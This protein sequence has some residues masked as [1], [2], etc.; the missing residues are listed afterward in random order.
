MPPGARR[1]FGQ[2][3]EAVREEAV[4]LK[5]LRLL[6]VDDDRVV[7]PLGAA[8][9]PAAVLVDDLEARD[10][11]QQA[12]RKLDGAHL[13]VQLH[14]IDA[15][16]PVFFDLGE[17]A[18]NGRDEQDVLD[19]VQLREGE[20]DGLLGR[21]LVLGAQHRSAV[22]EQGVLL[23]TFENRDAAVP[24]FLVVDQLRLAR[25]SVRSPAGHRPRAGPA[26]R[27]RRAALAGLKRRPDPARYQPRARSGRL[28]MSTACNGVTR[29]TRAKENRAPP[30][31][32]PRLS[33]MYTNAPGYR[34]LPGA[35]RKQTVGQQ[36]ADQQ[37]VR[38]QR[39]DG[40][41]QGRVETHG[42]PV[43]EED[44]AQTADGEEQ[45]RR[46]PGQQQRKPSRAAEP[47][48]A[49]GLRPAARARPRLHP[50]AASWTG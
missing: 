43:D 7:G 6:Q 17:H 47:R 8:E 14:V 30:A 38:R 44:V 20:V 50:A 28:A 24:G 3:K 16:R 48:P 1:L 34:G 41:G 4:G 37:A 35:K 23:P 42:R 39:A 18:A 15:C 26:R 49:G 27:T 40:V 25:V 11:S 22:A 10:P 36:K 31:T 2:R 32:S 12:V 9:P 19:L 46:E 29:E 13:R 33:A 45:N 21:A 5:G